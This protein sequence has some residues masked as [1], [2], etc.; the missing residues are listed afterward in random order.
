[1]EGSLFC[2]KLKCLNFY[3]IG[4]YLRNLMERDELL[5]VAEIGG[6]LCCQTGI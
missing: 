1:M 2:S 3:I 5:V 4:W 6:G